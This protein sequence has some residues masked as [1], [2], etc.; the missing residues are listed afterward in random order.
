M[1]DRVH[2]VGAGL[3]GLAA[4]VTLAQAGRRV[5]LHDAARQA[6]GRCRSYADATLGLTIDN[7]NHLL[8][9]GNR[10][11]LAYCDLIGAGEALQGPDEARFP[12]IDLKTG[13]RWTLRPNQGR[14]PWW[15]ASPAR[16]VPGSKARD[17]LAPAAMLASRRDRPIGEVMACTGPLYDRLWGPI[18][19]AGLNTPPAEGSTRLA[20]ALMRETLLAGGAACRPLVATGGLSAAFVDP[21]LRFIAD[22]GGVV[23]LGRRLRQIRLGDDRAQAL[24]FGDETIELGPGDALVLAVPASVAVEL[25]PGLTAPTQ[26]HAIVNAHFKAP[27]PAGAPP[28]IGVVNAVTEWVFAF[29]DRL[30]VTISGADR[31]LDVPREALA[32]TIWTEVAAVAGLEAAALPPWQIVT[33]KRATFAATPAQNARRPE[34]TTR[35]R[36]LLLAGDWTQTGLPAT[37]EGAIRSGDR[38]AALALAVKPLSGAATGTRTLSSS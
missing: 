3:A 33:E 5:H 24:L 30:S 19:L 34:A 27:P 23:G 14:I 29:E 31:L 11:A 12:F 25:V 38:A 17:Y 32:R 21:A 35:W 28:F 9:S 36:N 22:H 26:F 1:A 15:I 37:I 6:G 16:R 13:A 20:A 18:L 8:L 2:V 4:A 10:A 7:G